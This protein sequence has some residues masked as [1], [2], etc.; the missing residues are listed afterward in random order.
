M[1]KWLFQCC[2]MLIH[3]N[4]KCLRFGHG[5]TQ[6]QLRTAPRTT[7]PSTTA[8]RNF[9]YELVAG[10][11]YTCTGS[12]TNAIDFEGLKFKQHVTWCYIPA[13]CCFEINP[14]LLIP[15]ISPIDH[16]FSLV[17]R[18]TL[19]SMAFATTSS[20]SHFQPSLKAIPTTMAIR[21][22]T[23]SPAAIV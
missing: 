1:I 12:L 21:R 5:W 23:A 2:F 13:K 19:P 16:L 3:V 6:R 20:G 18:L 17:N 7:G 15:P 9:F 14:C 22:T 8:A 11:N 10:A 4:P